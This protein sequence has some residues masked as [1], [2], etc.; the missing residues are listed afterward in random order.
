LLQLVIRDSEGRLISYVE[1]NQIIAI[2]PAILDEYLDNKSNKKTVAK[3]GKLYEI[4]QWQAKTEI[5]DSRHAM[6]LYVLYVPLNDTYQ[7][8]LELIHNSYQVEP[9]DT[10]QIYWTIMRP[11]S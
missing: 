9:H 7:S 4:F 11:F 5:A 10:V 8:A 3:D 6:T 2:N 1:T